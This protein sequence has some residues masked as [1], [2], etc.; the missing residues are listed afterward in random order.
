M[1]SMPERFLDEGLVALVHAGPRLA[2]VGNYLM[3]GDMALVVDE[4]GF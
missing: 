1:V 4:A 2:V 3:N